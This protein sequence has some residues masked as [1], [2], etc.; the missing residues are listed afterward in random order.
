[1]ESNSA[2]LESDLIEDL[3]RLTHRRWRWYRC[4][5]LVV[6]ILLSRRA[7][8]LTTSSSNYYFSS[9]QNWLEGPDKIWA[10]AIAYS[11]I[12]ISLYVMIMAIFSAFYLGYIA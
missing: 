3:P 1:M 4:L 8:Q 5:P 6:L 9:F 10:L 2:V 11:I 7:L 12:F